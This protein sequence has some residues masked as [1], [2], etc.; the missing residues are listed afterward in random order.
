MP[1]FQSY[2]I[3]SYLDLSFNNFNGQV[4]LFPSEKMKIIFL[5]TNNFSGTMPKNIGEM[6][7][8]LRFLE[9]A[10][11][12]ITGR[13]PPSIGMLKNLEILVL[14]SNSLFGELP[15]HREDLRSLNLL[16]GANNN[17]SGKL[18]SSMQFLSSL[19]WLSLEKK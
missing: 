11:N 2:S 14:R 3:A 9:L 7:P 12:F 10:S 15:P 1:H 19:Q 5:H 16:D 4:P 8:N 6:L 18:P 17:I 13:I